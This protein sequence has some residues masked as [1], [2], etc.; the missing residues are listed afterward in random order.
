M[1]RFYPQI[2]R[3]GWQLIYP[4]NLNI[5]AVDISWPA[6][7]QRYLAS[8]SAYFIYVTDLHVMMFSLCWREGIYL[9]GSMK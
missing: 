9:A 5:F 7:M 8:A 2:A 3:W 4:D 6:T 1:A